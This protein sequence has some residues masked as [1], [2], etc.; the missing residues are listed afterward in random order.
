MIILQSSKHCWSI[1][2]KKQLSRFSNQKGQN[3]FRYDQKKDKFFPPKNMVVELV[4]FIDIEK[5]DKLD[6]HQSAYLP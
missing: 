1:I 5:E 2:Y 3:K 6:P 4:Y